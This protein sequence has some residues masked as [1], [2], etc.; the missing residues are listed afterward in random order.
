VISGAEDAAV[1]PARSRRTGEQIAGARFVTI[2]HAGHTSAIEEPDAV[3]AA[4][5]AFWAS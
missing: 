3:N 5:S 4:L 2:P 1:V